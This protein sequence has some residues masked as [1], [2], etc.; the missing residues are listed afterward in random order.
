M[1]LLKKISIRDLNGF[2]TGD[3]KKLVKDAAGE[4]FVARIIGSARKVIIGT[5]TFG[6]Y[7]EFSGDFRGFNIAGVE[8]AGGK[9]YLPEPVD[10]LLAGALAGEGNVAVDFAYDIF[11]VE[12]TKTEVGFQYRVQQLTEA[13]PS[14]PLLALTSKLAPLALA[15][16]KAEEPTPEPE[17]TET[18]PAGKVKK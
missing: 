10:A 7:Y 1:K 12:D 15:A 4:V 18:A 6:D 8:H 16:P 13:A 9:C 2:K 5:S 17:A 11:V 14:E 3:V